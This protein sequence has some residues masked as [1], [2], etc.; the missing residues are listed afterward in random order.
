MK[1]LA[2][3]A[4]AAVGYALAERVGRKKDLGFTD[5]GPV[6]YKPPA[7]TVVPDLPVEPA[8]VAPAVT[9]EAVTVTPVEPFIEP[10]EAPIEVEVEAEQEVVVEPEVVAQVPDFPQPEDVAVTEEESPVADATEEE[11]EAAFEAEFAAEL[12]AEAELAAEAALAAELLPEPPAPPV[13]EP[14]L[15][16]PEEEPPVVVEA[17]E[18]PDEEPIETISKEALET[19]ESN[20]ADDMPLVETD[21]EA[22]TPTAE[23]EAEPK[24]SDLADNIVARVQTAAD[25]AREDEIDVENVDD[26][27][28]DSPVLEAEA[29]AAFVVPTAGDFSDEIFEGETPDSPDPVAVDEALLAETGLMDPIDD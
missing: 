29:P 13:I 15:K 12:S 4:A 20:W 1:K 19:W 10:A 8:D 27:V 6:I 11:L 3:L 7:P 18:E 28:L 25:L 9:E 14:F 21:A 23:P 17:D 2:I 26:D 22:E 5:P 16:H 24:L